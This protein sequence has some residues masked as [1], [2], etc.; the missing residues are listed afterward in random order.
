MNWKLLGLYENNTSKNVLIVISTSG[1]GKACWLTTE[2]A[3]V[4]ARDGVPIDLG[5]MPI[6]NFTYLG[7]LRDMVFNI[8]QRR[9]GRC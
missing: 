8:Q 5:Y 6:N 9:L 1:G 7:D 2:D 3:F 4:I